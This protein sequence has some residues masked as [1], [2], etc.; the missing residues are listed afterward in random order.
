M[1]WALSTIETWCE[2][3]LLVN[4]DK[5][6]LVAFTRKRKPQGFF[7]AQT[8]GVKLSLSGLVK[9]LVVILDSPLTW[10]E[11][12]VVETRKAHN[13]LWMCRRACRVRWGLKPKVVHWLYIAIVRVSIS[14]C[15][16]SM[17]A[18]LSDS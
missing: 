7:E 14:F 2:F 12:V 17:V 3:G 9:H 5:T 6:G 13:L 18:W 16:H 4:P 11:H 10:R 8:F 15:I 1:Q